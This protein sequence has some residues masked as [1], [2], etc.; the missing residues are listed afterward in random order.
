M[1]KGVKIYPLTPDLCANINTTAIRDI[2]V[3]IDEVVFKLYGE[4]LSTYQM[5][6][7]ELTFL[8]KGKGI[9]VNL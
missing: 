6:N 9:K 7:V 5:G 2:T 3:Q 1:K 4:L 8:H